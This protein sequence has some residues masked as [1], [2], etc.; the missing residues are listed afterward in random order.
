MRASFLVAA[1]VLAVPAA[2]LGQGDPLARAHE[3]YNRQQYDDAIRFATE[4]RALPAAAASASIVLSRA[5]L[6][7]FRQTSDLVDLDAAREA[8][9]GVDTA[10]IGPRDRV[11]WTIGMGELL[12]FDRHFSTAAEFFEV[13]LAHVDLLEPDARE[14]LVEWWAGALDQQAQLG[15]IPDRQVIYKRIRDRAE[16]ELRRDDRS[17]VASYWLSAAAAG[18]NDFERAWGAAEAGWLRGSPG[19]PA[20]EKLRNDLDRLVTTVIAPERAR[21]LSPADPE[22]AMRILLQDWE[23]FKTQYSAEPQ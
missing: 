10:A 1:I 17:P 14:R 23:A 7:R 4:A 16:E 5:H 8:L 13:G 12:Y 9:V 22:S 3:Q 20:R 19:A 15:P 21:V 6:E 18:V 11:D 2:A